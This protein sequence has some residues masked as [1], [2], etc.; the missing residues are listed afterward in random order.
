MTHYIRIITETTEQHDQII[1][2]G[3]HDRQD[4]RLT[5]QLFN[6]SIDRPLFWAL[7]P[8][9]QL[10][11]I[12]NPT[13]YGRQT[14]EQSCSLTAP[15][16]PLFQT[17][18][19]GWLENFSFLTGTLKFSR[20]S[21]QAPFNFSWSVGFACR[22]GLC[23]RFVTFWVG[24]WHLKWIRSLTLLLNHSFFNWFIS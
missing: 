1:M 7:V 24:L 9:N 10:R 21:A 22:G 5:G 16:G 17:C 14:K 2:T 13:T 4:K 11:P 12:P 8:C 3:Q 6:Q 19:P 20:F 18:A 15:S 23:Q